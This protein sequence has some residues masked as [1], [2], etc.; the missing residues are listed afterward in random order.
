MV[1]ELDRLLDRDDVPREVRVDVIDQSGQRS[2]LARAGRTCDED[3]PA[4]QV[5]EFLNDRRNAEL[6]E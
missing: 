6:L 1:H 2:R 4:A 3:E 5:A